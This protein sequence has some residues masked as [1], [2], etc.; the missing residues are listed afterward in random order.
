VELD[1]GYGLSSIGRRIGG[2]GIRKEQKE[3]LR[4]FLKLAK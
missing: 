1:C 4:I 3:M 2:Y